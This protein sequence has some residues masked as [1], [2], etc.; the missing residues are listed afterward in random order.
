MTVSVHSYTLGDNK[1]TPGSEPLPTAV[2]EDSGV[3]SPERPAST[4]PRWQELRQLDKTLLRLVLPS[5]FVKNTD[6][7]G[8]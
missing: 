5:M 8:I 2:K 7:Q 6:L 1:S 3:N 4:L